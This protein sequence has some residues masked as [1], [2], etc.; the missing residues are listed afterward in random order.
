MDAGG[1]AGSTFATLAGTG[2]ERPAPSVIS[3][4]CAAASREIRVAKP[5]ASNRR[6]SSAKRKGN[7]CLSVRH[8]GCKH[9][10]A[11]RGELVLCLAGLQELQEITG[12]S[13]VGSGNERGGIDDRLMRILGKGADDLHLRVGSSIRLVNDPERCLAGR[14]EQKCG[15]DVLRL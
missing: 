1:P 6:R 3:S 12:G 5:P 15:P 11:L 4:A 9:R 2:T 10:K 14:D 8:D 7:R 13:V